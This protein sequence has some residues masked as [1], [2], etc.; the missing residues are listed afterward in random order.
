MNN[1]LKCVDHNHT[2]DHN[3]SVNTSRQYNLKTH[4]TIHESINELVHKIYV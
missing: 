2:L 3:I 4:G 1:L